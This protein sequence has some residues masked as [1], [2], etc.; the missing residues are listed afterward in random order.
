MM[1]M[2]VWSITD[3]DVERQMDKLIALLSPEGAMG[4]L[5]GS[6]GPYLK[7]RAQSRFAQEGD[8]VSGAWLPL[9]PATQAIREASNYP[10][11]GDHPINRR[12][13]ELEDWVTQGGWNS[14]PTA[15]GAS[16]QYPARQPTG[17]LRVKVET[18]QKGKV[19]PRTPPRPVLGV[20]ETDLLFITAA[21]AMAIEAAGQ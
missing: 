15:L 16:L 13:G 4:F 19:N 5:G 18:A 1:N 17:E 9:A 11:A 2:F 12:S 7:Q 3:Q 6:V 21:Y 10:V 8:D 20:N 14:Y